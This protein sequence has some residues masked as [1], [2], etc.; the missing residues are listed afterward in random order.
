[1]SPDPRLRIKTFSTK[2]EVTTI[3]ISAKYDACLGTQYK[4]M[5][6]IVISKYKMFVYLLRSAKDD[7]N[8]KINFSWEIEFKDYTFKFIFD[9]EQQDMV[10]STSYQKIEGTEK[11]FDLFKKDICKEILDKQS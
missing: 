11:P 10:F 5:E 3:S 8:R 2:E 7:G 6:A 4:M 9:T 1:M